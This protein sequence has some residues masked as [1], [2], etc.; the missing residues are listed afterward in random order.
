[1]TIPEVKHLFLCKIHRFPM[2]EV[3]EAL[4]IY[5]QGFK[6]CIHG[7]KDSSRQLSLMDSET[8]VRF[9]LAP[10][11]VKEN[12]TT[13]G[14]D[15]QALETGMRMR[16]GEALLEISEPC[17]PC[18]RMDD[19]RQGLRR[20]L[21]GQRGWLCRVVEQGTIR[22]GDGI[23]LLVALERVARADDGNKEENLGR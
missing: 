17:H 2:E 18:A 23:E 21:K 22:R 14:M 15:F 7:R 19:I 6:G 4:A 11:T 20:E 12:I 5:Q 10:G 13:V 9:G 8:L 16:V 1:M 3:E